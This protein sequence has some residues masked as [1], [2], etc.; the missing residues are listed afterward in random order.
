MSYDD[1]YDRPAPV[2]IPSGIHFAGIVWITL[3]TLALAMIALGY[4]LGPIAMV[5]DNQSITFYC[6][7]CIFNTVFLMGGILTVRGN[8]M[9]VLGNSIG[10]IIA[11]LLFLGMGLFMTLMG[12]SVFSRNSANIEPLLIGLI[13]FL[14]GGLFMLASILSLINRRAY[15]RWKHHQ[16]TLKWERRL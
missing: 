8:V 13:V 15:L 10:S 6:C 5:V 14:L 2:S 12:V 3:G 9:D 16:A 11:S 7:G 4:P 1:D